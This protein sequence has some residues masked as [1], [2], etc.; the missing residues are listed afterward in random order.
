M[1]YIG[2]NVYKA[3]IVQTLSLHEVIQE[4]MVPQSMSPFSKNKI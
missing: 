4:K 3:C 1:F 2:S